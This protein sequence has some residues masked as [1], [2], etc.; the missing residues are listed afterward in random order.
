VSDR[1][2]TSVD[3]GTVALEDMARIV[4]NLQAMSVGRPYPHVGSAEIDFN[5]GDET[6]EVVVTDQAG[7]VAGSVV[8]AWVNGSTSE[9]DA[10]AHLLASGYLSFT[11]ESIVAGT[12]FTIRG[13]NR[14]LGLTGT[15]N[16]IWEWV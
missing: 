6:A 9:N 1:N 12:G 15:F 4:R 16:V 2:A 10:E 3:P 11:I 8:R 5:H 14:E 13:L 7:I